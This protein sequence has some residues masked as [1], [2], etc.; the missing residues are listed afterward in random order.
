VFGSCN[1]HAMRGDRCQGDGA[2]GIGQFDD[3]LDFAPP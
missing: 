3:R 1:N 2:G